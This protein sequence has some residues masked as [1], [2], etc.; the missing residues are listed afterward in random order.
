MWCILAHYECSYWNTP[1]NLRANRGIYKLGKSLQLAYFY[2]E[3]GSVATR[4]CFGCKTV[5]KKKTLEFNL[6]AGILFCS[7]INLQWLNSITC[8]S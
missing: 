6:E 1:K 3:K 5:V 7:E 2:Y 8:Y 4:G